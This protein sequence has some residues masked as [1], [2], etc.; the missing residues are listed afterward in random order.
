MLKIPS[1]KILPIL[2]ILSKIKTAANRFP[3]FMKPSDLA[4]L[5]KA[6]ARRNAEN[7]PAALRE[8]IAALERENA[9]LRA[10]LAHRKA[11]K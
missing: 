8:R 1:P 2:L 10:R 9:A 11:A 7:D 5:G 4:E 3:I 6:I